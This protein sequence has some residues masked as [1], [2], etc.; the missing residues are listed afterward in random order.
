MIV[1]AKNRG[2]S[3]KGLAAYLTDPKGDQHRALWTATAN[4][5]TDDPKLAAKIMAATD[6]QSGSRSKKG[7]VYHLIMSWHRGEPDH[8]PTQ[9]EQL[10]AAQDLL[11]SLGLDQ[12]QA[13]IV[14]HDDNGLPHVHIMVN[15][16][17]P[18]R[19]RIW[20]DPRNPDDAKRNFT[21]NIQRKMKDWRVAYDLE[22]YGRVLADG[23]HKGLSRAT[24]ER[25][26]KTAPASWLDNRAKEA[27]YKATFRAE[28]ERAKAEKATSH[29][30]QWRALFKSQEGSAALQEQAISRAR[31]EASAASAEAQRTAAALRKAELRASTTLGRIAQGLHL[32]TSAERAS[33]AQNAAAERMQAAASKLAQAEIAKATAN[34]RHEK[35]RRDL[36][37]KQSA[38]IEA[39]AAS[40]AKDKAASGEILL[41][42]L[43]DQ[44]STFTRAELETFCR[45]AEFDSGKLYDSADLVALD[46]DRFTS[47]EL[48]EIER[49]M[50]DRAER[51][52]SSG[53][54]GLNLEADASGLADEQRAALEQIT[55][56]SA[57]SNVIGYAGAGKSFL[58]SRAAEAWQREGYKVQGAALSAIAAH[59]LGEGAGIEA[60]TLHSL[61]SRLECNNT[62]DTR[63]V[64]V[65]DEA[66]LIGSRQM[67]DLLRHADE[68][69]A[70][71]VLTGD[72][73]QLQAIDA[74]GAFRAIAK[75]TGA[76]E[77]QTVRRQ[78]EAWQ[79]VATKQLAGGEAR[80]AI[81][82]YAANGGIIAHEGKD[83]AAAATVDAWARLGDERPEATQIML[84]PTRKDVAA[85][86]EAARSHAREAGQLGEDREIIT[87]TGKQHFADGD[88]VLFTKND[89]ALG[90][91]NGSLGTIEQIEGEGREARLMVRLDGEAE[92]ITVEAAEYGSFTHGYAL[93]I[94]KAQGV[95][96]DH[97]HI[98][99]GRFMDNHA[100]Y[101][102]M[103]RH[104]DSMTMHYAREDFADQRALERT[105]SRLNLKDTTLDYE[106][107]GIMSAHDDMMK[108]KGVAE[109]AF[110]AAK[111][112]EQ[113]E[114]EQIE[115]GAAGASKTLSVP[116]HGQTAVGKPV[117]EP[118]QKQKE[119]AD[120]EYQRVEKEARED[121]R[122]HIRQSERVTRAENPTAPIAKGLTSRDADTV[123]KPDNSKASEPQKIE[124][125]PWSSG[126]SDDRPK[127]QDRDLGGAGVEPDPKPPTL[128]SGGAKAVP[129]TVEKTDAVAKSNTGK[130]AFAADALQKGGS[131]DATV[132]P[133]QADIDDRTNQKAERLARH[134]QRKNDGRDG[135]GDFGIGD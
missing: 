33:A 106:E 103:S 127:G 4:M 23:A 18:E 114:A 82:T 93:T 10:E 63:T 130:T 123:F 15:M 119:A 22:H 88:R 44:K 60:G 120:A 5:A 113:K 55:G 65:V 24:I 122:H 128:P 20:A 83:D 17:D 66:G 73:Q 54:H 118:S 109:N 79:A 30:A 19:G 97:A 78:R 48:Q 110:N 49:T 107:Q 94:H 111:E 99:A 80:R 1:S 77:L 69:G 132:K 27:L 112:A 34:S 86:N 96:V 92:P 71:V 36:G 67:A 8:E 47:R 35:Q 13:L 116:T 2:H 40:R 64:L 59:D 70:K 74:G 56:E 43:T 7:N 133:A 50:I 37:K 51:M 26:E 42:A 135:R 14:A 6:A 101:V 61:L 131:D 29:K 9:A 90:V 11:K 117:F 108:R 85:L 45:N 53:S 98:M 68:A 134:E 12:A 121:R 125:A 3:F 16:I 105:L 21:S 62:L 28:I 41:R 57:L 100:A 39:L 52:A 25:M 95:T 58:L 126:N 76:S 72:P 75:R 81:A 89:K 87:S 124:G 129:E 115:K 46:G 104:R 32:V 91:K 102:A 38:E 31:I 84:A